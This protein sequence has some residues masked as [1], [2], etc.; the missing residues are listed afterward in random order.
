MNVEDIAVVGDRLPFDP[1]P[2]RRAVF[3]LGRARPLH[4]GDLF[5]TVSALR[6]LAAD[7]TV[8]LT[9]RLT[10]DESACAHTAAELVAC[11]LGSVVFERGSGSATGAI[12]LDAV[13]LGDLHG[14]AS[15]S[16]AGTT[17]NDLRQPRRPMGAVMLD[18]EPDLR[19]V[20]RVVDAP[21]RVAAAI[22]HAQVDLDPTLGYD[23]QLRP[24]VANLAVILGLLTDKPPIAALFGLHGAG[25]LKQVVTEALQQRLRPIRALYT[26]LVADPVTLS[27]LVR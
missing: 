26:E 20:V 4:L 5:G 23:P 16:P 7:P 2:R 13:R 15:G 18:G 8:D 12:D 24:G 25:Q 6:T 21:L 19:G 17:I 10:G 22:R 3:D 14:D 11:G 9:V 1:A 27:R